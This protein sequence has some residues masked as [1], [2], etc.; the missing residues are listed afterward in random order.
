M[1][2][3][4]LSLLAVVALSNPLHAEERESHGR[5]G[6]NSVYLNF[7]SEGGGIDTETLNVAVDFIATADAQGNVV[8]YIN[9]QKG[10]E[11]ERFVCVN[12]TDSTL[13]YQFLKVV[14]PLVAADT[15]SSKQRTH[16]RVWTDCRSYEKAT[17][18][19]V[20]KY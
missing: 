9:D 11:G 3:L 4:I 6:A 14:A 20:T 5:G 16:V 2:T 8:E 7:T 13:R 17:E 15:G 18:Q 19:D 1:K 12:F 10:R